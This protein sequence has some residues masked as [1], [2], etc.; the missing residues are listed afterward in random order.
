MSDDSSPI[1]RPRAAA[2]VTAVAASK[3]LVAGGQGSVVDDALALLH[4]YACEAPSLDALR[5][6]ATQPSLRADLVALRL[7]SQSRPFL[8]RVTSEL[9]L[10]LEIASPRESPSSEELRD[11]SR[12]LSR[13]GAS[14]HFPAAVLV[15][16]H[17]AVG[18]A[19]AAYSLDALGAGSPTRPIGDEGFWAQ[20]GIADVFVVAAAQMIGGGAVA[21]VLRADLER[22]TSEGKVPVRWGNPLWGNHSRPALTAHLTGLAAI[23]T[24]VIAALGLSYRLVETESF[25]YLVSR[26][27][28]GLLWVIPM[29]VASVVIYPLPMVLGRVLSWAFADARPGSEDTSAQWLR[30]TTRP[31]GVDVEPARRRVAEAKAVV[32]RARDQA[33]GERAREQRDAAELARRLR[34]EMEVAPEPTEAEPPPQGI[35]RAGQAPTADPATATYDEALLTALRDPDHGMQLR[36]DVVVAHAAEAGELSDDDA[37]LAVIGRLE[38]LLAALLDPLTVP[39]RRTVARLASQRHGGFRRL[40]R[41]TGEPVLTREGEPLSGVRVEVAPPVAVDERDLFATRSLKHARIRK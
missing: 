37:A 33:K 16:T 30:W 31:V 8:H 13:F 19:L 26:F 41:I 6:L 29:V 9:E 11:T 40:E 3:K 7:D 5:W 2:A 38:R 28:L 10:A 24:G 32:V 22:E 36:W 17:L 1:T 18:I 35:Y 14:V 4:R 25:I 21:L 23:A 20:V 15:L 12:A 39:E 34:A 27:V